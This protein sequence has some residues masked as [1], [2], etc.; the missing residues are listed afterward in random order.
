M[1]KKR[2]KRGRPRWGVVRLSRRRIEELPDEGNLNQYANVLGVS[3]GT[4]WKWAAE[5]GMP[6]VYE[7]TA[8]TINAKWTVKK[9]LFVKWAIETGRYKVRPEY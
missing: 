7:Y 1:R 6:R 4:V 2:V 3:T 8:G 9:D 5:K